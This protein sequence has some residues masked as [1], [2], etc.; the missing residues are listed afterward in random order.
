MAKERGILTY[1]EINEQAEVFRAVAGGLDQI[2]PIFTRA[3]REHKPEEII[4]TGCGTSFHLAQASS[5]VF[6][7]FNDIPARAVA[8]SE[9]FL[10]PEVYFKDRRTLVVPF[11]RKASTTEVRLALAEAHKHSKVKTLAVSCDPGSEALNDYYV[12]CPA[13]DE[14]SV[15]MTKSFTSMLYIALFMALSVADRQE[16]IDMAIS[17]PS[18][19]SKLLGEADA[20]GKRIM[21][22]NKDRDL[23]IY[24]GQGPF[25]GLAGEAMIKMKEMSLANAEAY[26]SLE[27]R[28]GP[29]SLAGTNTLVTVFVSASA[30]EMERGL[31]AELKGIGAR[32][33]AIADGPPQE[34]SLD[35][36]YYIN[37]G[38]G[39]NDFLR[40]P[41][42]IIPAQYMAY[43]Y[44]HARG[45]ELDTPRHLMQAVV[46]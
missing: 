46:M 32:T 4:F 18:A 42:A 31:L 5:V 7:R 21:M 41:L 33:F 22:E 19:C 12:P 43:H 20:I 17:I 45:L 25:F 39:L 6:A 28:H 26:H 16:L 14:Q 11:T 38:S 8:S 27:Y 37:L 1:K 30:A 29:I 34:K 40:L 2:I 36:D 9:L 10:Y 35:A 24:L 15:V 23:F 13:G 44:A 3:F